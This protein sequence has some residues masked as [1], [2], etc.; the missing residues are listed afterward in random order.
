MIDQVRHR[1]PD[2]TGL[3]LNEQ[4]ALAHARLSIIDLSTGQQ[5]MTNEGRSLWLTFNGEIFNYLELRA[6]LISRGHIFTTNSDTEVIL[7]A[8]EEKGVECVHDFNGQW[9]FA[10][11]DARKKE[12][13]AARDRIGIRPLFFT[14]AA[15]QFIFGSEI[16]SLFS[17]PAVRREL[18]VEAL[19]QTFTFWHPIAPRTPFAGIRELPPGHW[20]KASAAGLRIQRYWELDYSE[21]L[22]LKE[23]ECAE[24]L[25]TLLVE[26]TRLQLRADVPI[27]AYLSGG[28]DSSVTTALIRHFSDA[29][30]R[31]FSVTFDDAE[32]DESRYQ[33]EVVRHL[34]TE[35]QAINCP[36]QSIAE[37]FPAVIRHT[38]KPVLRTAPAPLY[39]LSKLV[40][41]SGY[42]VVLTGEGADEVLGG[43]DIFKEAKVRRFWSRAP[44]SN[45]RPLLLRRLYPYMQNLQ[46]QPEAYR[47]TFFHVRPEDLG[48]PF[49]SHL[50]RW[51]LTARTKVMFSEDLKARLRNY[52][53]YAELA[54]HL[55]PAFQHWDHFA[56]AQYLETAFLLPGYILSSQGDRMA[57]GH[58]VEGR[59]PFLDHRVI[60]FAARLPPHLKMKVLDE[61]YLLKRAVGDLV[62]PSVKARPKQP[63]RAPDAASFFA[64]REQGVRAE[65]VEEMLSEKAVR[66]NGLFNPRAVNHLVD[67]ARRGDLTGIKD[68]MALV[69][70]LSTQLLVEE[71]INKPRGGQ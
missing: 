22:E 46:A 47:R 1:G 45:C 10:L 39:L 66:A 11:W 53:G 8:Y 26:S 13:F 63:Y 14:E 70:V 43:Y 9:S 62:P 67:K 49:F 12:L 68:N 40:R 5:P 51:E 69:G 37:V 23:N 61:K 59:F 58:S 3:Y 57:M 17:H 2:E 41:E 50:P 25:L 42:K 33:Q 64:G 52:D 34:Q 56:Q 16:K 65:Y 54:A 20:L 48:S 15:G 31:S 7:H 29:R 24:R 60:E 21:S 38:E 18:D 30:L 55:P 36:A 35:H 27:G 4:A 32:F 6:E 71:F 19:D 28:L 44:G